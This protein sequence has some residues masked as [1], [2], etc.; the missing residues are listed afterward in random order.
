MKSIPIRPVPLR[1]GLLLALIGLC[2]WLGVKLVYGALGDSLATALQRATNVNTPARLAMAD[3]AARYADSDPLVRWERGSAYLAAANE[4]QNNDYAKTAVAELRAATA[5]SPQDARIWLTFGK[6]LARAGDA[7]G[8]KAAFTKATELA[9]H[10][11]EP[12]WTLGNQLLRTGE[13]D[14]AFASLQTALRQ[15][16]NALPLVFD[17]AWYFFQGDADAVIRA[18]NPPP[19][20][21][22]ACAA[23]LIAH[24]QVEAAMKLWRL[25]DKPPTATEAQP[26]IESLQRIGRQRAAFDIWRK[27]FAEPVADAGSVLANGSFEQ[28]IDLGSGMPFL[29][30]Q[31]A[32]PTG[33]TVGLDPQVFSAGALSLRLRFDVKENVALIVAT[34]TAPVQPRTAYRLHCMVKTEDLQSLSTPFI[35]IQDAADDKRLSVTTPAVSSGSANWTEYQVD[36]VTTTATEAVTVRLMR[37]PC[38]EPPCPLTGRLWFDDFQLTA[39]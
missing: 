34:Q 32:A 6:A 3:N 18:L 21:R 8:A 1:L 30:W 4:T 39:K 11:F 16:P 7:A 10:H 23:R 17:Y 2:G 22:S 27:T 31:I 38:Q 29:T 37:M 20:L 26:I 15:R 25:D 5:L 13:R 33:V 9:P 28:P 12:H 36:F 19:A 14:A 35:S 24:N